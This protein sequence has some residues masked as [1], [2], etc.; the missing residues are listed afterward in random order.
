MTYVIEIFG[1][2]YFSHVEKALETG[3]PLWVCQDTP[4]KGRQYAAGSDIVRV[5][6]AMRDRDV[7]HI[8][9]SILPMRYAMI[10]H[11]IRRV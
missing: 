9:A 7:A 2:G 5:V 1:F 10:D 4:Q 3:Q 6:Q 8:T 11:V